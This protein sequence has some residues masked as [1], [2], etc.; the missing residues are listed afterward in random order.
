V[1]GAA[2]VVTTL[3]WSGRE[4]A[5]AVES[6]ALATEALSEGQ[7]ADQAE[8]D[9]LR[10]QD[11]VTLAE[12]GLALPDDP[13]LA[14]ER[15]R[16]LSDDMPWTGAARLL[17]SDARQLGIPLSSMRL[18]ETLT[19][20]PIAGDGRRAML[21]E[22]ATRGVWMFDVETGR[23]WKTDLTIT[24]DAS[25]I[26]QDGRFVVVG[27]R[28]DGRMSLALHDVE[29]G[30]T[31]RLQVPLGR[32]P[33]SIWI[34]PDGARVVGQTDDAH[35]WIMDRSGVIGDLGLRSLTAVAFVPERD[36][37]LVVDED[38]LTLVS[39]GA[40]ARVLAAEISA[41]IKLSP[42]G[43]RV[44]IRSATGLRVLSLDGG[45]PRELSASG[46][47]K[48]WEGKVLSSLAIF[49]P[50]DGDLSTR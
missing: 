9:L 41:P 4:H 43:D 5:H 25:A 20:G 33:V 37:L 48:I 28:I 32:E 19:I 45:E 14:L 26:S 16:Q 38:R 31:Q 21:I 46:D 3:A 30:L 12:A 47:N 29:R 1:L 42:A 36:E 40:E 50:S 10:R 27:E 39:P 17:A 15:L 44:A 35:T 18:P 49:P 2:A 6:E 34:A 24:H 13:S 8:L 7:R 23:S 11:A 22:H